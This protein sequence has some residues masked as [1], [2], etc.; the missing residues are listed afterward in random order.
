[1][2]GEPYDPTTGE[3]TL[4]PGMPP[5]IA[6]A[7]IAVKKQVKQLG[8][9]QEN[10]HGGY[11]S[12]SVDKMYETVG[13]MM[14]GAGLAV[15]ID[16]ISTDVRSNDKTGN[17]W[18]FAQY[19]LSFMHESGVMSAALRRSIALPI[20]GPQAF[21]SAQSYVEKQFMRQVF[22]VPT[23]DKDA[24]DT[25]PSDG[26]VP[27]GRTEARQTQQSPSGATTARGRPQAA[28]APSEAKAEAT[29]RWN[30]LRDEIR[31]CTTIP[32]PQGLDGIIGSM[33]WQACFVKIKEAENDGEKATEAMGML[34]DRITKRR[35]TL[36]GAE[37]EGGY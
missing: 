2:D 10:K 36:L 26:T 22:K 30:E 4:V 32:A 15:I 24:D 28:P 13:Q 35:E 6:A 20:S 14:A 7:I 21:G 33:A 9:D 16:E 8:F 19:A 23:G 34:V 1:M 5:V 25:A 37:P 11:K 17:A 27:A 18:L 3:I 12:V 29:K 31:S